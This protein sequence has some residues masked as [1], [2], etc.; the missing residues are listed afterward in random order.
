MLQCLQS[1][2]PPKNALAAEPEIADLIGLYFMCDNLGHLPD[3][4]GVLDMRADHF[5]YF[6]VFAAAKAEYLRTL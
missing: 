5:A 1:D 4:G 2:K 6:A 3:G